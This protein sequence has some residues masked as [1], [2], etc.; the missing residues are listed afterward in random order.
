MDA[1]LRQDCQ[2]RCIFMQV[3]HMAQADG[4]EL[5]DVYPQFHRQRAV[6]Q[7]QVGTEEAFF[8]DL[9]PHMN[10]GIHQDDLL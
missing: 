1:F 3:Q 6:A 2:R 8:T 10:E 4:V 5:R 9:I 7:G